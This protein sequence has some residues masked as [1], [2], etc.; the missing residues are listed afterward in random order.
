[1]HKVQRGD[2][3][4]PAQGQFRVPGPW[5][6]AGPPP[7]TELPPPANS[8]PQSSRGLS[9]LVRALHFIPRPGPCTWQEQG[10]LFHFRSFFWTLRG[11]GLE[12]AGGEVTM[13]KQVP[14]GRWWWDR[15]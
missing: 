5:W 7:E 2:S 1:M 9:G 4:G 15:R 12:R 11:R 3:P 14:S 8:R 13:V 6:Q 10:L